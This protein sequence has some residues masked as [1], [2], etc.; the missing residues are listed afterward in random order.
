MS[1][2]ANQFNSQIKSHFVALSQRIIEKHGEVDGL[3]KIITDHISTLSTNIEVPPDKPKKEQKVRE[4]PL[5]CE[6]RI[7]GSG[8]EH[9]GNERCSFN[10]SLN[11]LCTKHAKAETECCIP[12]TLDRD[13]KKHLGLFYGRINQFQKGE[14][15]IP[16]YKDLNNILR[17]QWTSE[18]MRRHIS[19]EIE[20]GRCRLLK[21][22]KAK[23]TTTKTTPPRQP[24]TPLPSSN[25]DAFTILGLTNNAS[26]AEIK[27]KYHALAREFHPDKIPDH[28][29]NEQR[30]HSEER[31]KQIN[32]AWQILQT[33][34]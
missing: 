20:Q 30:L 5:Q 23:K 10:A 11:G 7:W 32:A 12:C 34:S 17:V 25:N 8:P 24:I 6:A 28:Y 1:G 14:V 2:L 18:F 9:N 13:G 27:Q 29:T 3:E 26:I 15:N 31:F 22:P 16:P 33:R 4:K 19:N 21:N